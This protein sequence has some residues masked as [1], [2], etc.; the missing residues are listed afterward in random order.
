M[1]TAATNGFGAGRLLIR[2]W[3]ASIAVAALLLILAFAI[4]GSSAGLSQ[5]VLRYAA[6]IP[7]WVTLLVLIAGAVRTQLRDG[8][9]EH[10]KLV[11]FFEANIESADR[12]LSAIWARVAGDYRRGE[13]QWARFAPSGL[14][15]TSDEPAPSVWGQGCSRIR[16]PPT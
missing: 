6:L 3:L 14:V 5:G 13:L 8:T 1:K 4:R 11:A 9:N 10:A 12:Q 15:S 2:V 16:R 7:I